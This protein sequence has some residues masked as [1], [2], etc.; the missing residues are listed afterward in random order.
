M[1]NIYPCWTGRLA[2]LNAVTPKLPI[3]YTLLTLSNRIMG[4]DAVMLLRLPPATPAAT[5]CRTSPA[6]SA[7]AS[8]K[9]APAPATAE[10][11]T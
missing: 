8:S 2:P 5:A 6:E 11:F 3:R 4:I 10:A 1:A 7:S 9:P